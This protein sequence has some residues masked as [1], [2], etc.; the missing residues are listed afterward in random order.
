MKPEIKKLLTEAFQTAFDNA[1]NS[2]ERN[3]LYKTAETLGIK[4]QYLNDA[5]SG[6]KNYLL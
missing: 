2:A 6:L 3:K 1:E 4:I 5:F